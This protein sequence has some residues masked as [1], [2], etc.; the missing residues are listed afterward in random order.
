MVE[1]T[2]KPQEVS[3][4]ENIEEIEKQFRNDLND[5]ESSILSGKPSKEINDKLRMTFSLAGSLPNNVKLNIVKQYHVVAGYI[6]SNLK[7]ANSGNKEVN[8][9]NYAW[10]NDVKAK[11]YNESY[12]NDLM[13]KSLTDVTALK[14]AMD[15][16]YDVNKGFSDKVFKSFHHHSHK[17]SEG[18][19]KMVDFVKNGTPEQFNAVFKEASEDYKNTMAHFDVLDQTITGMNTENL[20]KEKEGMKKEHEKL[21]QLDIMIK[22][23][24]EAAKTET[25]PVKREQI[26]KGIELASKA[27]QNLGL[28]MTQIDIQIE[29]RLNPT[30]E[31]EQTGISTLHKCASRVNGNSDNEDNDSFLL[32]IRQENYR[33]LS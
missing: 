32:P 22:G 1:K 18:V 20:L 4:V 33:N 5:I 11:W 21:K 27:R 30:N 13:M 26:L 19:K 7:T 29:Q 14:E 3:K 25:D 17:F 6:E 8:E 12:C 2:E 24:E 9:Q 10:L 23:L 31:N 16:G 15:N 28:R